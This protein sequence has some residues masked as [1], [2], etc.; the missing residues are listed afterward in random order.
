VGVV[1]AII[2]GF[3]G[4][5]I[6]WVTDAASSTSEEVARITL[7][8]GAITGFLSCLFLSVRYLRF[9]AKRSWQR[10]LGFGPL[11][12]ALSGACSGFIT[13]IMLYWGEGGKILKSSTRMIVIKKT[14]SH[15]ENDRAKCVF[16]KVNM[17]EADKNTTSE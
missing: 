3:F 13:G 11:F 4:W 14:Y 2:G 8:T 1:G 7:P 12:G 15:L 16:V 6:A 10:G 5:A 9:M 17:A